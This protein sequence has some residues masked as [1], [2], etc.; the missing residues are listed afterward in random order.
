MGGAG[1]P[2][3]ICFPGKRWDRGKACLATKN[4]GRREVRRE[5]LEKGILQAS[6]QSV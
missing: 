1:L 3:G 6:R 5:I 2:G 4:L